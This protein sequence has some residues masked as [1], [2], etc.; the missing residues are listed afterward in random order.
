MMLGYKKWGAVLGAVALLAVMVP[1]KAE[2]QFVRYS[3]IFWSIEGSA[4]YAIPTGT[5]SDVADGGVKVGIGGAYF[6]NPRLALRADGSVNLLK[7][8]DS[9]SGPEVDVWHISGGLEYHI[10]DPV[11]NFAAIVDVGAG[12]DLFD[13]DRFSINDFPTTGST[14]STTFEDTRFAVN[15][16]VKLG[17]NFARHSRTGTPMV[18]I[19]VGAR[20]HV[21][22]M[23]EDDLGYRALATLYSTSTSSTLVRI[24][25]EGGLRI[26]IP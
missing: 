22:F 7:A 4:G 8:K 16:G 21:A 17:Y 3:P 13:T 19:W 14:T 11:G 20:A 24:P 12:V 15:G 6:L 5:L 18:Q 1:A 23:D 25:V 26:N 10:T 9:T 2:A